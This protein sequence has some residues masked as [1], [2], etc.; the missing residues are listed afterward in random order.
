MYP[1]KAI[2]DKNHK[3]TMKSVSNEVYWRQKSEKN[4]E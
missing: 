2:G 4:S 1:M 3:K